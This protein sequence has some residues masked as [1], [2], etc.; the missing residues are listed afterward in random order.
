M[1]N[2]DRAKQFAPFDALIGFEEAIEKATREYFAEKRKIRSEEEATELN[3]KLK[4]IRKKDSVSITYYCG[5]EYRMVETMVLQIDDVMR[6]LVI[7]DGEE[8][9]TV[10]FDD[11]YDIF[12]IK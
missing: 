8:K 3:G 9:R 5:D 7:R 1:S 12:A 2:Q 4:E 6:N 10:S 11:I